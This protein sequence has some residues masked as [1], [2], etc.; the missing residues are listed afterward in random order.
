[1]S[2]TLDDLSPSLR[3]WMFL[4]QFDNDMTTFESFINALPVSYQNDRML[5][6][7]PQEVYNVFN[8]L[9]TSLKK[10]RA[11]HGPQRER[12]KLVDEIDYT[13]RSKINDY[14]TMNDDW[15][16]QTPDYIP[17]MSVKKLAQKYKKPNYSPQRNSWELDIMFTPRRKYLV[18]ININTRY[19]IVEPIAHKSASEITRVINHIR[20]DLGFKIDHIKGDGE[21]GFDSKDVRALFKKEDDGKN[22][23]KTL[24]KSIR[25]D[26][27]PYTYHNKQVDS[28]IRTLRNSAGVSER[29]LDNN[30]CVQKLVEYYNNTPHNGLPMNA[31]GVHYTPTEMMRDPDLEWQYIRS[32]DRKLKNVQKT[33]SKVGFDNYQRGNI[34]L[35]HLDKGKTKMSFMKVR[36]NFD[37]L[38][39]FIKY[40][41]GSVMCRWLS[42]FK[43]NETPIIR[44]PIFYTK[45]VADSI[46]ELP[47][48]YKQF[49]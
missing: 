41:N 33:L 24:T 36:R 12:R 49:L 28:F 10:P 31:I 21:A 6:Q 4:H 46:E 16:A 39:E 42:S 3:N 17:D 45:K 9:R 22:K 7:Y 37:E 38:G 15:E 11:Y 25:L 19:A 29:V 26:G 5:S 13:F 43:R 8:M 48:K 14:M 18:F 47:E 34:L 35:L 23:K 32:M 27:S 2:L 40:D 44:V 1:M 20:N 30:E